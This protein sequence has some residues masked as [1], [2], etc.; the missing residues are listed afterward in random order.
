ML[1]RYREDPTRTI[2]NLRAIRNIPIGVLEDGRA[3]LI[4]HGYIEPAPD[5]TTAVTE[6][7]EVIAEELRA[8]AREQLIV[9]L[10]GWSPDQYPEL[11]R[12]LT[13]LANDVAEAPPEHAPA[14]P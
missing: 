8:E 14:L 13:R 12:L 5:G 1:F 2:D 4:E 10:D 6:S 7:G 9:L 11:A 3:L